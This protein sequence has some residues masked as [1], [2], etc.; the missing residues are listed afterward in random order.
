MKQSELNH[1]RLLLGWV[2]TEIGQ[3]PEEMTAMMADIAEKLGHPPISDDAQR[4]LVEGYDRSRS[5]PKY[6]RAAVKA[7]GKLVQPGD[8][9]DAAESLRKLDH[10][11]S[12]LPPAR[13]VSTLTPEEAKAQFLREHGG[14]V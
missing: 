10:T 3:A 13:M 12:S 8:V 1:L 6:V 14:T 7:L 5:V 4:R 9:E 2:R 11:R